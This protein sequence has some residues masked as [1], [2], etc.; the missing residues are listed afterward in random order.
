MLCAV[1]FIVPQ[2]IFT[3][4]F[5]NTS[6]ENYGRFG[7]PKGFVPCLYEIDHVGLAA[8]GNNIL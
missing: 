7:T 3:Q 1:L 2:N 6:L 8:E 4:V 5:Y